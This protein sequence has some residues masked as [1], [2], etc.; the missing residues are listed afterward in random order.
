M[1]TVSDNTA[2]DTMIRHLEGPAAINERLASLSMTGVD[3]SRTCHEIICDFADLDPA[4]TGDE[5]TEHL[6]SLEDSG[7]AERDERVDKSDR[8]RCTHES[9]GG[10][11]VR[12]LNGE[13]ASEASS[14]FLKDVMSRNR[15][16][17]ERIPKL[18][19][20]QTLYAEKTGTLGRYANDV[21]WVQLP[22]GS[23]LVMSLFARSY[24]RRLPEPLLA[25]TSRLMFDA[26]FLE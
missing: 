19:P 7:L 16:G 5:V 4:M 18:L 9:M 10:V 6:R 1:M 11:V 17:V 20:K 22:D 3:I 15:T 26:F 13:L 25:Q 2:T 24:T 23:L 21:G 8:D 12:L 14:E